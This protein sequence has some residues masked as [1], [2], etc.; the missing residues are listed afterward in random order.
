MPI[1]S[2]LTKTINKNGAISATELYGLGILKNEKE[3]LKW[4]K[5]TFKLEAKNSKQGDYSIHGIYRQFN[6][7]FQGH[8][9]RD[10]PVSAIKDICQHLQRFGNGKIVAIEAIDGSENAK[11]L[12]R[13]FG[14]SGIEE[15]AKLN[16]FEKV[17]HVNDY[18][19]FYLA[20]WYLQRQVGYILENDK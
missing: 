11:G 5:A 15:L 10:F 8:F 2:Y 12:L 13:T 16:M 18:F 19:N 9:K 4:T 17:E 7:F 1:K 20:T 6:G 14:T 3:I